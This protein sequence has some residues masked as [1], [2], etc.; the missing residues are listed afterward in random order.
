MRI[1]GARRIVGKANLPGDKSISHRAGMIGAMARGTTRIENFATS[2][3]CGS[4]LK[5]LGMLG[6]SIERRGSTVEIKGVGNGEFRQ[7]EH[8]LDCGNSGTTMRLLAGILA[9]MN[10]EATLAGDDSLSRRP[11]RRVIEPLESMGARIES[12]NGNAPLRIYGTDKLS[13]IDFIPPVA[14]AQIKSCVLLAG[15][16]AEGTTIV[17]EKKPTRDH[18]ERML[19]EFGAEISTNEGAEGVQIALSG[20]AN[21][22]G[23]GISVP[24][25]IS[26][27]A[28]LIAAA[29]CLEGSELVLRNVGINPT[30]RAVVDVLAGAGMEIIIENERTVNGEPI[31]EIVVYGGIEDTSEKL[32]IEGEIIPNLIDEIPILAVVGSQLGGGLEVRGAGELRVKESDRIAAVVENLRRMGAEV[33]E[34]DDGFLVGHARLTGATVDSYG[35]HRI[36]MA[37]AVAGLI[38]KGETVIEGSEAV[39]V[40]F[41]GFFETLRDLTER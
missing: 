35:D 39:D 33:E 15:L 28:F 37:F 16:R 40:S 18:T 5:C 10:I 3:D 23:R 26:S 4:T 22:E 24:G 30:R 20:D 11:M 31:A 36:A 12:V 29:G 19:A 41:P 2:A 21:L 38:A 7:P 9:G 17:T 14:S 32:I 25:D 34:Y 6:V 1:N 13:A 8:E 27:A